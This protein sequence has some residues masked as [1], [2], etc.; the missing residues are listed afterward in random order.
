MLE[1][2]DGSLAM[3]PSTSRGA[4]RGEARVVLRLQLADAKDATPEKLDARLRLRQERG[5]QID[6]QHARGV[7]RALGI[8]GHPESDRGLG[9][10]ELRSQCAAASHS[11][12]QVVLRPP[13]CE[14]FTT[15]DPSRNAT[16]VRPPGNDG[17]VLSRQHEGAQVDVARRDAA[18][19]EGR[20]RGEASV[21]CAM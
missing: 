21:G 6:V 11:S 1:G 9:E 15:R 7:L 17:D 2:L 10:H 3:N 14:E 13:P 12:T 16:R 5:L 4:K 8:A 18:L 20:A 19:D